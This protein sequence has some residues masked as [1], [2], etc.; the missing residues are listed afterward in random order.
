MAQATLSYKLSPSRAPV[1]RALLD[2]DDWSFAAKPHMAWQARSSLGVVSCY[3]SGSLVIQ[4]PQADIVV[5]ILELDDAAPKVP[6]GASA[7]ASPSTG[8]AALSTSS[9]RAPA[10]TA[11]K[12][13][14][15]ADDRLA[16]YHRMRD[17]FGEPAPMT[18]IGIDEAGKGDFFGPLVTAAVRVELSDLP[19]LAELGVGDS[20]QI[21]DTN[22]KQLAAQLKKALPYAIVK[23]MP[24]TYNR[25]YGTFGNLNRLLAWTHAASA[26]EVLENAPA[27]L[28]FSDQ[29][30]KALIVPTFFKG[31]GKAC[32]YVQQTKAE[33][34][35]AVGCASILA[36]AEFLWGMH[37]LS[38]AHG[39]TLRKGAGDPTITD[40][41]R[42]LARHGVEALNGVAKTHFKT[43]ETIGAR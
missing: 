43:M 5:A 13:H 17:S 24:E 8:G 37:E 7:A 21:N 28:I 27:E 32:R 25:L 6:K 15:N 40:A 1:L 18:W 14:P 35:A 9:S 42:F 30:T 38:E 4:S 10:A 23:L 26:E 22:V 16:V 12:L 33:A 19:W 20:K 36:R 39:M 29:F 34:D 41:K 3:S 2:A 31:P 11:T